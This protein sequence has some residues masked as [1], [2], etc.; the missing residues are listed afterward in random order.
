M[1]GISLPNIMEPELI[2]PLLK[3]LQEDRLVSLC[4]VDFESGGPNVSAISWIYAQNSTTIHLAVDSTSRIIKN[5]EQNDKVVVTV[6]ANESVYSIHAIAIVKESQIENVPLR[7]SLIE[8]SI[9]A[10]RDVMFYG[11]KLKTEPMYEKTYDKNAAQKLDEQ[12][13]AALKSV[14]NEKKS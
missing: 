14:R 4:T 7:L 3:A 2:E 11:A 12:I 9:T 5:V 1:E 8:L 6:H 10:V 13:Y